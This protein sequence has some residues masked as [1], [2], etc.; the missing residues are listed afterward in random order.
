[1][2][3]QEPEGRIVAVPVRFGHW[4]ARFPRAVPVAIFCLIAAV[5]IVSVVAIERLAAERRQA[6]LEQAALA[7]QSTIE[8]RTS[9]NAMHLR[10]GA[11][12]FSTLREVTHQSFHHFVSELRLKPGLLGVE[13]I[14][15]AAQV[16]PDEAAGYVTHIRAEGP[17]FRNFHIWPEM[18]D[19]Q[20]YAVPVT[21]L[22]PHSARNDRAVGYDMYSEPVRRSAMIE[23]GRSGLPATSG[24]LVLIQEG[25][26]ERPGLITFMPVFR[27]IQGRRSL[28]GYIYSPFTAETFL[29]S[30]LRGGLLKPGMTVRLF[31]RKLSPENELVVV[32]GEGAAGGGIIRNL[33]ID[34]QPWILQVEM[35]DT[36]ALSTLSLVTLLFGMVVA[37]LLM[38]LARLLTQQVMED[39]AALDFLTEQN[40]IRNSLTR[41]LNHRVKN[42]LANVLSIIALTRRR[43]TD[44]D[45]F[46]DS[47]N[48]RIRALSATHDLLTQSNWASTPIQAV[49]ETELAPYAQGTGHVLELDGPVVELAPNDALSLGLA[50]HELATNASKYGAL[51]QPGGCVRVSWV[52]R[53]VALAEVCWS[54]TGGPPVSS[55][56]VRGFGTELIEKIVA[57]ELGAPVDLR[58]EPD[59]VRCTLL[60]PVRGRRSEF[61]MRAARKETGGGS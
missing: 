7:I 34:G 8:R 46:V 44:L 61:A 42:T 18:A 22:Y 60:V 6:E 14:G 25:G 47:L 16:M 31:H 13:G 51:S 35:V 27:E 49:I 58:F 32:H 23:A 11:A 54:E 3:K 9:A 59:G 10:A 48:G 41:E 43:A 1:M 50:I 45:S 57:H 38:L 37:T 21:Y 36:E 28:F 26:R 55:S 4:L 19:R 39:R 30:A 20:P 33:P 56:R 15:W 52:Q 5:T 12:I 29:Q 24:R 40:S 17:L 2:A 53:P